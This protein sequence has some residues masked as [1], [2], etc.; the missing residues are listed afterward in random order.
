MKVLAAM[1]GGV[2]SA[3]AAARAV[4]AGHDVVGVHLALSRMPG[5]LRTGSRGCCTIEDSRDAWRACDILG[6]PYYVWDFSERFKEDVVDDF[7]AEYAAGRTPNP[8]MRC[9]E[10]IK[11]AA[12]LEKALALGFDAVC[13]GHYAK[14][15]ED[16]HGNRELHRA[17]DW[18]KDQ[19]YVLGVLTHEQ[20]KHSM[21]PL[22]ETPSKAEVR[23][24]AARRGLSVANKPDSHDICFISDGDTR[25]WLAEKIEME[26]GSIV[27][28]DGQVV[29]EHEG[30]NAFT[31][32]QRRGL[33][34]GR[35]APDGKPRFVLEIRPKENKV[36]VGPEALLA[37]DQMRGI[38][39]SWAGLPLPEVEAQTSFE[40]MVQ[41]RAHGDPV[42]ARAQSELDDDGRQQLVVTLIEP[43]RGVAP[44][45]T[46]VLYQGTRVLGQAT[47]DSARSLSWDPA[48]VS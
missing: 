48:K 27:D 33:K 46:M 38:K 24:E 37:V 26:S 3:V 15:I 32:G 35:P 18:A 30:A 42:A 22:A 20:L 45:Q 19:S 43:M 16:E 14:V 40:C 28:Q 44:G 31:V 10:R 2:D 12:L 6:I 11:F 41:V 36:V 34:L 13:T 4:E 8:C 39:V 7:I 23:A 17:A 21:F 47:I 1:S 25:G 29:G 9:N 5:T